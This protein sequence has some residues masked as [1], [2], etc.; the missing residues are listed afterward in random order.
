MD[1]EARPRLHSKVRLRVDKSDG[2]AL[3]VYPERALRLNASAGAVVTLCDGSRRI[4]DVVAALAGRYPGA[5]LCELERDVC[6]LL[7]RLAERGLVQLELGPPQAEQA[8]LA[9]AKSAAS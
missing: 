7:Q 9:E 5:E 6:S 4:V 3:L 8:G 1:A 2:T